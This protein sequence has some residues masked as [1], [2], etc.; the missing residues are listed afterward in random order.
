MADQGMA[1][2]RGNVAAWLLAML[3]AVVARQAS[4]QDAGAA[5]A[6]RQER[7]ARLM[8]E[9][10]GRLQRLAETLSAAEP[11]QA[12][13]L[14]TARDRARQ[15]R[16]EE[17]MAEVGQLLQK[18]RYDAA[19]AE[20]D[21]LIQ[22]LVELIRLL[23]EDNRLRELLEM[24]QLLRQWRQQLR[25]AI[26]REQSQERES[27]RLTNREA[28]LAELDR[29]ARAL[30]ELIAAQ[31]GLRDATAGATPGDVSALA[32][33]A[34]RQM[35]LRQDTQKAA[36]A[37]SGR[38]AGGTGSGQ[39]SGQGGV[40]P[41]GAGSPGAGAAPGSN[42]SPG[43]PGVPGSEGSQGSAGA[44]GEGVGGAMG[45]AVASQAQAEEALSQG[46]GRA[47][48]T[49]Q[50]R[51]LAEL[52][53]ALEAVRQERNRIERLP[54]EHFDA[55]A[56]KESENAASAGALD[57]SMSDASARGG[58]ESGGQG[59][60]SA[61]DG[62]GQPGGSG[63]GSG[64]GGGG[65]GESESM[66]GQPQVREAKQKMEEAQAGL[67]NRDAAAAQR[68]QRE[69]I[70]KLR[71]AQDQIEERLAQLR[72]QLLED[73]LAGLETRFAQ[74]LA[75][76]VPVTAETAR[77]E[78]TR[79]G[80]TRTRQELAI[81]HQ[82]ALAEKDLAGQA[83]RALD[84]IMEDGSTLVFP[85]IVEELR[86]DLQGANELLAARRS[87]AHTQSVQADIEATLKEL[88][89]AMQK[90]RQQ[91]AGGGGG[92][93]GGG[94]AP[95]GQTP[96]VPDSAELKLLRSAQLRVNGRTQSLHQATANAATPDALTTRELQRVSRMQEDV[97]EMTR[98][99][100]ER[101]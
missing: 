20:Q 92:G 93:G 78:Q 29:Q 65:G 45:R 53:R 41:Q 11:E 19:R 26:E 32:R 69:A 86:D 67:Q 85:R 8:T 12:R 3:L 42:G 5:L 94:G 89:E 75:R 68:K 71:Q 52:T 79:V 98:G 9:L 1:R 59:P 80:E 44:A 87:D 60:P 40:P 54:P 55:L 101:K 91:A 84:I 74:M 22:E 61:S 13:R 57:K 73:R 6:V 23:T 64:G 46:R 4:A 99:L 14:K 18:Q 33:L 27:G 97:R 47:G 70:D 34:D 48:Q 72:R 77:L 76:Q 28:T 30:T 88:I 2:W 17:R 56:K 49:A 24:E 36:D 25:E 50:E 83:Q 96:L 95:G 35:D 100:A 7:V 66:P 10:D 51:A 43:V 16:L 21:R 62:G 81:L 38:S 58:G 15:A 37:L 90:A 31:Q 63:E 82:L 39:Q